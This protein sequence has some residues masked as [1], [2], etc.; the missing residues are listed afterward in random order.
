MELYSFPQYGYLST[1]LPEYVR[2][3]YDLSNLPSA[4]NTSLRSQPYPIEMSRTPSVSP[5]RSLSSAPLASAWSEDPSESAITTTR[6]TTW[7]KQRLRVA[8]VSICNISVA[9]RV[10]I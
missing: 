8:N 5:E 2:Q 4:A 6:T 9:A 7:S 3:A 1:R 10:S